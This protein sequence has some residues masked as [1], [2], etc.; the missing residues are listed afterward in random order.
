MTS[1][2]QVTWSLSIQ[3]D[4][5][6]RFYRHFDRIEQVQQFIKKY[7]GLKYV[8]LTRETSRVDNFQASLDYFTSNNTSTTNP[9]AP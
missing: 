9:I 7:P 4:D 3:Y 2:T 5:G 6:E 1:T 8:S